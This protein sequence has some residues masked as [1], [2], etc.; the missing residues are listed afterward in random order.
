MSGIRFDGLF[1]GGSHDG[2]IRRGQSHER[3]TATEPVEVAG[4]SEGD[5]VGDLQCL[6]HAI[7]D[8]EA[9]VQDRDPGIRGID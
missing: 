8:S 9:M 4:E 1:D 6:E 2:R 5:T 3:G 7:G